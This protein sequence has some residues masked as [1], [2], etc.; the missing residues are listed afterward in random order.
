MNP[1]HM[2]RHI[3]LCVLALL[4]LQLLPSELARGGTML[5]LDEICSASAAASVCAVQ[6]GGSYMFIHT[7]SR[8]C[9]HTSIRTNALSDRDGRT[10][11]RLTATEQAYM[12]QK[13]NFP[14]SPIAAIMKACALNPLPQI[15]SLQELITSLR[16]RFSSPADAMPDA[17]LAAR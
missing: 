5:S 16:T 1:G 10:N 2:H 4:L 6:T 3:T 12:I 15:C 17:R 7:E 13:W 9:F 8:T 11:K 14:V